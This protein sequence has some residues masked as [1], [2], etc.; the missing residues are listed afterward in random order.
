MGFSHKAKF[1]GIESSAQDRI[2][3]RFDLKPEAEPLETHLKG[4]ILKA[5]TKL[6]KEELES[7]SKMDSKKN[8]SLL[9]TNIMKIYKKEHLIY[10]RHILLKFL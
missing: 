8:P 1:G 3:K 4:E 10:V 7:I 5:N 6:W 2:P 9:K